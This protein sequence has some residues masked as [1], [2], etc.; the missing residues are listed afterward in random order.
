MRYY[1]N[2]PHIKKDEITLRIPGEPQVIERQNDIFSMD[3]F[4]D[5]EDDIQELE[6]STFR[7]ETV[8]ANVLQMQPEFVAR[9]GFNIQIPH[10]RIYCQ[11]RKELQQ[12]LRFI[13]NDEPFIV[14]TAPITHR[15]ITNFIAAK[16]TAIAS[17]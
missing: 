6:T 10:L 3:S 16:E 13:Y 8:R 4:T 17:R 2:N 11:A 7:E 9:L 14:A 15:D 1:R 12:G 5:A